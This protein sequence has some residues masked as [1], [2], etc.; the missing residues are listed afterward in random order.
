MKN[1]VLDVQGLEVVFFLVGSDTLFGVLVLLDD[2]EELVVEADEQ[3]AEDGAEEVEPVG[4]EVVE[5]VLVVAEQRD[6][7]GADDAR[8]V[9]RAPGDRP[10]R[11]DRH[12]RRAARADAVE[13]PR[14]A[15][16]VVERHHHVHV[17]ARR[18]ELGKE[19]HGLG[20]AHIQPG[21][22]YFGVGGVGQRVGDGDADEEG[23]E[24][25]AERLGQDE[26]GADSERYLAQA[27]ERERHRPVEVAAGQGLA[28]PDRERRDESLR[29][30][31]RGPAVLRALLFVVEVRPPPEKHDRERP[32]CFRDA[33]GERD[34][35]PVPRA[36]HHR[37]CLF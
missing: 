14:V 13:V 18:D 4:V 30:R 11:Q 2:H 1:T 7:D 20:V 36:D 31:D 21:H 12:H 37:Y 33:G 28:A 35:A 29:Q 27:G 16:V 9:D 19:A 3:G 23:R 6:Q 26:P 34:L 15:A 25:R 17:E 10:E 22:A 32:Q 5:D 8:R 24:E